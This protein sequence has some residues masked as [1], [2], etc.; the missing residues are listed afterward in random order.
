LESTR[1][2]HCGSERSLAVGDYGLLDQNT[3][4]PRPNYWA[5][6][7]WQ[8]L[9]GMTVLDAQVP[10]APNAY[11]FAQCFEGQPG[12]VTL[13][14]INADRQRT[15]DHRN[16]AQVWARRPRPQWRPR[17]GEG[18][19]AIAMGGMLQEDLLRATGAVFEVADAYGHHGE[20]F[21]KSSFTA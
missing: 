11:V 12:G 16:D 1:L 15:F 13:L 17:S 14:V 10:A 2:A 8:K 18:P 19:F 9:M 4:E 20:P 6:V 7:L 3:L 5:S 21:G